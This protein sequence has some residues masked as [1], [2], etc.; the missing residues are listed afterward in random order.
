[1]LCNHSLCSVGN[2]NPAA[3]NLMKVLVLINLGISALL[4]DQNN[5]VYHIEFKNAM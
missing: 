1:M 3:M 2:K 5:L 4:H